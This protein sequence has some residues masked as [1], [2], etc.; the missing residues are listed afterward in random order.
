LLRKQANGGGTVALRSTAGK[1]KARLS[2]GEL[3]EYAV[4]ALG[5]RMRTEVELRRLMRQRAELG[6]RGEAAIVAVVA[7][8]KEQRYL[9]DQSYAETYARLRQENDKLGARRVRRDLAQKGLKADL[10]E[11]TVD[12][13]YGES[14]EETLAR[15]HLERKRIKK[16]EN[17]RETARVVRR[18][19]AAGFSTGVIMRILRHW[20]VPE[21]TLAGLENLDEEPGR[22]E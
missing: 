11:E 20:D 2:E 1:V 9:D 14:N 17:E 18:L 5:R 16:P 22:E 10:I 19:V 12:A 21:E 8:L 13:R 6:E 15:Q 4:K 7:R 3:Y